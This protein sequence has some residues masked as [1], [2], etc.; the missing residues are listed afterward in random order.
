MNNRNNKYRNKMN[1]IVSNNL[2]CNLNKKRR[3]KDKAT[4]IK[5]NKRQFTLIFTAFLLFIFTV[6]NVFL[7]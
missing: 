4:A 2:F 5:D 7:A 1:K 6:F 3:M